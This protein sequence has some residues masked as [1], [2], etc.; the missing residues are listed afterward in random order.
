MDTWVQI[1][2]WTVYGVGV[3]VF[4][5][6]VGIVTRDKPTKAFE[7]ALPV[8]FLSLLWPVVVSAM[9]LVVVIGVVGCIPALIW[10]L[11]LMLGSGIGELWFNKKKENDEGGCH[12]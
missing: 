2:C 3:L 10:Y 5:I 9:L 4:P 11:L 12:V 8:F 1:L 6:V 7:D